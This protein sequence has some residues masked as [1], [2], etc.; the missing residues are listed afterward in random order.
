[1]KINNNIISHPFSGNLDKDQ[2][3]KSIFLLSSNSHKN[4]LNFNYNSKNAIFYSCPFSTTLL[5]FA[6][7]QLHLRAEIGDTRGSF[8]AGGVGGGGFRHVKNII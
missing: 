2:I 7:F 4:Y 1:M 8:F 5:K 3:K 6:R